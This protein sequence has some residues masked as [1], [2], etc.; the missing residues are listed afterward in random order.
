MF[1]RRQLITG[2]GGG[3]IKNDFI[4]TI[5]YVGTYYGFIHGAFRNYGNIDPMYIDTGSKT[6]E[7]YDFYCE[8]EPTDITVFVIRLNDPLGIDTVI[9]RVLDTDIEC[10]ATNNRDYQGEYPSPEIRN[11][12]VANRNK[13]VPISIIL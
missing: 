1:N 12:F 8:T 7:L 4:M 9:V 5:G 10:K 13:D 11:Y 3:S 2:T 6:V